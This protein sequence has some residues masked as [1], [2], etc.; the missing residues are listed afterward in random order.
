[1]SQSFGHLEQ[2]TKY[3]AIN[4]LRLSFKNEIENFQQFPT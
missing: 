1:M 2:N 3:F 4:L